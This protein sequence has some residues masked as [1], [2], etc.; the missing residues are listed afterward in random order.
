V[1]A[2]PKVDATVLKRAEM[3]AALRVAQRAS[4]WVDE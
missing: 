3:L 1:K 2:A 4:A